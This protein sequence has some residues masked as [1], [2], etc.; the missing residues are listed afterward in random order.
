MAFATAA[1]NTMLDSLTVNLLSLHTGDPGADGT[2]NEVSGGGYARVAATF[3][4]AASGERA[5]NADVQFAGP[6]SGAAT[7]VGFWEDGA[8]DVFHG[9]VA[10]TGDQAFNADGE[11]IVKGTTTKLDLNDA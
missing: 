8:P 2:A 7:H 10:L 4:A 1:K 9:S 5:L 6:A 11:Y 3:N